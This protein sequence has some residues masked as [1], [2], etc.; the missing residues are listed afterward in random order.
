MRRDSDFG[1]N[2]KNTLP[3]GCIKIGAKNPQN[4]YLEVWD[5]RNVTDGFLILARSEYNVHHDVNIPNTNFYPV[6]NVSDVLDI[7]I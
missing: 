1:V 7:E 6:R 5:T 4:P 3:V 2:K